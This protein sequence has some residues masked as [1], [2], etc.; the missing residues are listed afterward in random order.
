MYTLFLNYPAIY[1]K[2]CSIFKGGNANNLFKVASLEYERN[3]VVNIW[4]V[5]YV[6]SWIKLGI[7]I[8]TRAIF[9]F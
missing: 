1:D 4:M 3:F 8:G 7:E 6:L 5:E 2:V 9:L